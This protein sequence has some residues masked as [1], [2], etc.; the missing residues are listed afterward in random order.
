MKNKKDSNRK[1]T[2]TVTLGPVTVK[3]LELLIRKNVE[4]SPGIHFSLTDVAGGAM[5]TGLHAQCGAYGIAV[6][7]AW[8]N[9][10]Q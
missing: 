9:T 2:V 8:T 5:A 1:K 6:D 10:L 7:G 4:R 3:L